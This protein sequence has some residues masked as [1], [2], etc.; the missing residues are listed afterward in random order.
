MW[1]EASAQFEQDADIMWSSS[2]AGPRAGEGQLRSGMSPRDIIAPHPASRRLSVGLGQAV[3]S[4]GLPAI[5]F[6]EGPLAIAGR[7]PSRY[8]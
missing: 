8:E 5:R 4:G 2:W 1:R 7:S 3:S 6:G